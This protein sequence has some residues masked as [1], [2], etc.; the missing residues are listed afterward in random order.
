MLSHI[1]VGSGVDVSIAELASMIA[2]VTGFSGQIT[3]DASKPDGPARKLMDVGRLKELGWTAQINLE[4]GIQDTYEWFLRN[5][6]EL[7]QI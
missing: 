7:R 5:R 2:S 4:R 6:D 1:N 3:F